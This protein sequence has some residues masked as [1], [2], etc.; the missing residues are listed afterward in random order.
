[1]AALESEQVCDFRF[2]FLHGKTCVEIKEKLDEVSGGPAPSMTT[3]RFNE[4][5]RGRTLVFDERRSGRPIEGTT[6]DMVNTIHDIV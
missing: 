2:L 6:E 5:K 4:F 1:M 3:I